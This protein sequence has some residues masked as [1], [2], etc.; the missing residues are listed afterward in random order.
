MINVEEL[1]KIL[2]EYKSYFPDHWDDEKYKWEAI[3]HF[4]DNWDIDASN[5]GEMFDEAT[6]KTHNLLASGFSYPKAMIVNFAEADDE[7]TRQMFR[8]LYD[9]SRDLEERVESFINAAETL[10]ATHGEEMWGQHFQST[11][12]ISTYLWLHFPD[13]YYIYKY[14]YYNDAANEL[15]SDNKPK[16]DG[17]AESMK[18]GFK[19][20]DEIREVISYDTELTSMM[21]DV[22]TD[23][24]YPDPNYVTL[25]VDFGHYLSRFYLKKKHKLAEDAEWF[26]QDYT[27]GLS[28]D[29]WIELL[30][31][32]TIFTNSSLQIMKRM[33]DYGGQAT[34]T[35]LAIKYGENYNFYNSGSTALAR[36]IA[37]ETGITP[38]SPDS[39]NSRWW[40]ILYVGKPSDSD[41]DGVYIW[42]LRDELSEALDRVNLDDV[43]LYPETETDETHGYW[44]LTANPKIWAFTNLAVGEE[45]NFTLYNSRGNKRRIFQNFLEAK[46]GDYVIGYETYPVKK[47]TALLRVSQ[48]NDG[49]RVHF[50]KIESLPSPIAYAVLKESP[51]L[52][53]MEFF[54]NPNGSFFRLSKG[55]FDYIMDII[56]E[57][58]PVVSAD[59]TIPEYKKD[60][61]LNEVFMPE[62]RY[63]VLKALVKNKKNIILQGAPGVGKTFIAK[64]LAY[65]IM[66]EQDDARV[67][68]VQFHQN[69]SYEDFVQGYRPE[70]SDFKLTDGIFYTFCQKASNHPEKEYF[71][72]ID[73]INRG[74]LSKIFGELLVL[75]ENDKRGP[76]HKITLAYSGL[77]F[78]VPE[79]LHI[80]GMM[81][82][83]DRSLA[84][85]D[86]ALR[87][88]FSFFEIEPGFNSEGF[89]RYQ[90]GLE[91]ET[92][93]T[94]IEQ[95][96][97]LNREIAEDESLGTGFRIGHSYFCGLNVNTC[98]PE[99]MQSIVEFD[100]LPTLS[101]YW[102]DEPAKVLSWRNNLSGLFD[103]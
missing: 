62:E 40:P 65:S 70:G 22:L 13:K 50:Q 1:K 4:Q 102:F 43:S 12:A 23:S 29:E 82:T 20:Y 21:Q 44:W 53:Q 69:Y 24:C 46:N 2:E 17:S 14:G 89:R 68:P 34:C 36:R 41:D 57:E 87:R 79:N 3:K 51:E 86:Y 103:D 72:I 54:V 83:A 28:V 58:N 26:P 84:M 75:I 73:E 10:R 81:N 37:K 67:E 33:K 56:R 97:L 78:H 98:T 19:M 88:R 5:F 6:G 61:F 60:N 64:R 38:M 100:I 90:S 101:E 11:N 25:T 15:E 49:E 30:N 9:E 76:Q 66:G 93:D 42:K 63:D 71:F 45:Q 80:I 31:N 85:I 52:Q 35:Q 39:E 94:L 7:A 59:E 74:N 48:E 55:E 92:F 16:R 27:P 32:E 77:P 95:I 96:K 91:N 47:V 18:N 8:E 99:R